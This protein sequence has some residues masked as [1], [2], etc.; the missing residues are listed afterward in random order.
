METETL[1]MSIKILFFLI[2]RGIFFIHI[3]NYFFLLIMRGI[4]FIHVDHANFRL[5]ESFVDHCRYIL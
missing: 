2:F 3:G 4:L 5:S 1:L